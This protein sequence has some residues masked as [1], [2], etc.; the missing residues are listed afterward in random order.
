MS[1][2]SLEFIS[3]PKEINLSSSLE[4]PTSCQSE[5]IKHAIRVAIYKR[6][7]VS[8]GLI[9]ERTLIVQEALKFGL[10]GESGVS[11]AGSVGHNN[12]FF[13]VHRGKTWC[14]SRVLRITHGATLAHVGRSR[15]FQDIDLSK[16]RRRVRVAS[17]IGHNDK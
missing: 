15:T 16:C 17:K 12:L 7:I 6:A 2:W 8:G 9:L 14:A 13:I 3:L 11:D 5:P 1:F 4:K 10:C